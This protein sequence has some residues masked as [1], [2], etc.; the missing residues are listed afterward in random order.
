MRERERERERESER[1]RV[2]NLHAECDSVKDSK[3]SFSLSLSL[4]LSLA[5]ARVFAN[6]RIACTR[7]LSEERASM[8]SISHPA[9]PERVLHV[10]AVGEWTHT[11]HAPLG[12]ER[13][14]VEEPVNLGRRLVDCHYHQ[15]PRLERE[16][17]RE[18][19]R[20]G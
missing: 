16:R 5:R 20:E 10:R 1:E 14:S 17:D 18:R 13:D 19:D 6:S 9:G 2:R 3:A 8:G 4:S 7:P 12:Q 11:Q 15:H